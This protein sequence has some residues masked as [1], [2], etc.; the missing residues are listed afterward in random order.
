MLILC[1]KP[2]VAGDFAEALGCEGRHGY[3]QNEKVTVTYCVGHLFELAKPETYNPSYKVWDIKKL[4]I[5]PER[6]RYKPVPDVATQANTVLSLLRKYAGDDMVVA[7]DAGREGEL[8]ARIVFRE[9]GI[10]DI[11]RVKRFWVSEALT[12]E[13][14]RRG[15]ETAKPWKEYDR[16]ALEGEVR[17]QA[18]WLIGINLTRYMTCGNDTLFSVGRVQ[19]A[20][21]NAIAMRNSEVARFTPVPYSEL[22]ASI[23]SSNGTVVRARLV[24]PKTGKSAFFDTPEYPRTAKAV[25]RGKAVDHAEA[26]TNRETRKPEK[27]LN[28]TAL[29][30]KAFRL[31]GY[32]PEKTLEIAQ[33]LYEKHKCLSYPRT[34]GRVMGD[35]NADLFREK[36]RLLSARYPRYARFCD[37][38]IITPG[39]RNIFDSAALEDHH[40]LIPLAALPDNASLGEKNIYELV[41]RSFFI[42]CMPDY[43]YNRKRLV[44]HAG[45][46]TFRSVVNEVVQKGYRAAVKEDEEGEEE[47]ETGEFDESSCKIIG[48]EILDRKT[49]P[50]KEF[51]QDTLLA[52][53]EN[54]RNKEDGKLTGLGT[55]ATRAGIIKSLFDRGYIREEKKKLHATDKG[56]FLLKQLQKDENLGRIADAGETTVWEKQLREDP[57]GFRES[58]I[59]YLRSCI[60]QEDRERYAKDDLGRCPLCGK[61]VMAGRKNYYCSGYKNVPPCKF[62]VW[63]E[64]AGAAVSPADIKLLVSGKPAAVRKCAG[65]NGKLFSAAMVLDKEGKVIFRFPEK[66]PYRPSAA[67]TGKG[68]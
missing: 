62:M 13:V 55:P 41:L 8:I 61:P 29:Q 48:L 24:N 39:N 22:E 52:F 46:Y 45:E 10:T 43:V 6:F 56:L 26:A 7:T 47:Q 50:Q 42:V 32:T 49:S 37:E 1:E 38:S 64:I 19:T 17:Q 40:A 54:P 18:D 33:I 57:E 60:K 65:K 5:I 4:P 23:R 12:K 27:L 11:S 63:K 30:K 34:P 2:S 20:L 53:M 68:K 35:G 25:L 14:I 9:A 51:S 3:Y 21:L 66:K 31:H 44:F 59:K 36:Y 67:K 15:L 58:I 16:I 28:I